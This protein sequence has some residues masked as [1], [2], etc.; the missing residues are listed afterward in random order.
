[1]HKYYQ[2]GLFHDFDQ[3]LSK[4]TSPI[5]Q[6]TVNLLTGSQVDYCYDDQVIIISNRQFDFT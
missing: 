1:M 6:S 5:Y 4:F 2:V 3:S